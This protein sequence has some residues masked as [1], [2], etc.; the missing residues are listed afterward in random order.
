VSRLQERYTNQS[1][2]RGGSIGASEHNC[3]GGCGQ[4]PK[5]KGQVLGTS[6]STTRSAETELGLTSNY[7]HRAHRRNL[8]L[9]DLLF[10][11]ADEARGAGAVDDTVIE[12][13]RKRYDL[14]GLV[15]LSIGN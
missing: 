3:S 12:C 1:M 2:K 8:K 6:P 10:D 9:L 5:L 14:R 4:P 7:F 13:E 11:F 15:F